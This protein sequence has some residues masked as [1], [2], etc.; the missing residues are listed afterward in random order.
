MTFFDRTAAL[1]RSIVPA[2]VWERVAM[3]YREWRWARNSRRGWLTRRDRDDHHVD[4][5]WA[6]A[7]HPNRLLLID[8]L[9]ELVRP[10]DRVLEVGCHAGMNL[11]LLHDRFADKLRYFGVEPNHDAAVAVRERLP[12]VELLEGDDAAFVASSFP[13]GTGRLV[14]FINVVLYA[15][16]PRRAERILDKLAQISDAIV[17]GEELT[18]AAERSRFISEPAMYAHPYAH[19]LRERG[20]G[21]QRTIAIPD[22][23]PQLTGLLVARRGLATVAGGG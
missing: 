12:F 14:S 7:G 22:P 3:P 1:L 8:T 5:Y 19:W 21:A 2:P 18:N 10:G 20:F 13:P 23:R 6:T 15:V 9:A 17:L 4:E 16:E 11:K